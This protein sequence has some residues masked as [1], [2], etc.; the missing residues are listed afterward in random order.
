MFHLKKMLLKNFLGKGYREK[1]EPLRMNL[2][3]RLRFKVSQSNVVFTKWSPSFFT[4][5]MKR[6]HNFTFNFDFSR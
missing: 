4:P 2:T 6:A 3:T 1:P 5:E